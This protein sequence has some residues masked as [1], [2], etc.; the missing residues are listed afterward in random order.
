MAY[1]QFAPLLQPTFGPNLV[2]IDPVNPDQ[3]E[4]GIVRHLKS[5]NA[6]Q[7]VTKALLALG[8]LALGLLIL[9][10]QD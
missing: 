3:A 1:P 5:M 2:I 9:A 10:P 4:H 7:N 8:T 6:A